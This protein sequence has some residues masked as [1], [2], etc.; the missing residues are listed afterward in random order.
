MNDH[1]HA[2][3]VP[4]P[5]LIAAGALM[6]GTLAL[7]ATSRATGFGVSHVPSAE[8][9]RTARVRFLDAG[10]EGLSMVDPVSG[11]TFTAVTPAEEGF[12]RG[13]LRSLN[14]A[15]KLN[16]LPEPEHLELTRWEDGR[17]SLTDPVTTVSI[18]LQG[19]GPTHYATF[20]RL[21]EAIPNVAGRGE[22]P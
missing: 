18:Q 22:E 14:R 9:A 4:R 5:I 11:A 10:A 15:R 7:S 6:A 1:D 3:S 8:V 2:I 19:F 20:T 12:V 16:H 21:I 13:V 17:L